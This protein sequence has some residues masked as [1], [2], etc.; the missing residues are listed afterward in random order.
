MHVTK[1]EIWNISLLTFIHFQTVQ[2]IVFPPISHVKDPAFIFFSEL[3]DPAIIRGALIEGPAAIRGNTVN[4][5][6]RIQLYGITNMSPWLRGSDSFHR[7]R[8]SWRIYF[9]SLLTPYTAVSCSPYFPQT[10]EAQCYIHLITQH[11]RVYVSQSSPSSPSS[12]TLS[13]LTPY[14]AVSC[15]P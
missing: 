3:S 6:G 1:N 5:L 9:P 11:P 13:L 8:L 14:T 7:D 4:R 12:P 10:S 15:S 2:Y